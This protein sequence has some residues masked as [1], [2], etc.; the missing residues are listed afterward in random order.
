L[1]TVLKLLERIRVPFGSIDEFLGESG[2]SAFPIF[3]KNQ[4]HGLFARAVSEESIDL[5]IDLMDNLFEKL[6]E[7]ID[8]VVIEGACD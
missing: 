8:L 1:D 3:I 2:R 5:R 7:G 6:V 4:S